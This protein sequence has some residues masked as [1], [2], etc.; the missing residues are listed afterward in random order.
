MVSSR[1]IL[2]YAEDF[3]NSFGE[4]VLV[5][6]AVIRKLPNGKYTILSMK[7]KHLGTYDT[8]ADAVRRLR[9]IEW[10]KS[11]PKKKKKSASK[12]EDKDSY[13]SIMR[14]LRKNYDDETVKKFQKQFKS[15][16]DAALLSGSEEPENVLQE[17]LECIS[18]EDDEHAM[19]KLAAA[20]DMGDANYAGKYLA[21]LVKFLVKRISPERRPKSVESLRKKI[22]YLNE[23]QIAG[24]K[25]PPSSAMGHAISTI[26][27]V[28]L[29]HSPQYIRTVL[30]SIARNL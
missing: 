6:I 17:A 16:F 11:H 30:N 28:L 21:D 4:G 7:G 12:E 3:S 1:K 20:I 25:T 23:Y 26:K 5:K 27:T 29:E 9:Q 13:S 18:L 24:K 2:S 8:K 15:L 19:K 10:F 14:D 22:Y